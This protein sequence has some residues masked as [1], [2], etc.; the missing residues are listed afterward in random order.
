MNR[1]LT[2]SRIALAL[3]G[4]FCFAA[5][6]IASLRLQPAEKHLDGVLLRAEGVESKLNASA[7][8]LDTATRAWSQS[9]KQQADA[10]T[11]LVTDAHGT[12]SQVNASVA[13]I[14][15]VM[16]DAQENLSSL[17]R[18]TDNAAISASAL[19]DTIQTVNRSIPP[20]ADAYTRSGED[21]DSLLRDGAIRGTLANV[22]SI[23]GS[24]AGM[25]GDLDRVTNKASADY[26]SPKPWYRKIGRF[27]GDA[28]DYGALFARHT[29]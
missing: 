17:R 12:L 27:A 8:N 19:T 1:L 16:R 29:P 14:P 20:I 7:I 11:D 6:G 28:F 10:I 24:V 9:A 25:S 4:A 26:L 18:V 22:Q 5:I 23:T 13:S 15:P 21:L 2:I 3:S